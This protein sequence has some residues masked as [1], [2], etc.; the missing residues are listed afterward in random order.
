MRTYIICI[1]TNTPKFKSDEFKSNTSTFEKITTL[2]FALKLEPKFLNVRDHL[3]N[4]S[5]INE[6]RICRCNDIKTNG[7]TEER[8]V[9][10]LLLCSKTRQ[11]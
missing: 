1:C 6:R 8:N 4:L 2:D 3:Q 7:M 10:T 11:I 9:F 5:T